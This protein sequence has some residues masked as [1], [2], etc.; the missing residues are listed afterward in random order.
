MRFFPQKL[1]LVFFLWTG[2]LGGLS[3]SWG[4]HYY[5]IQ[6]AFR[7]FPQG[8]SVEAATTYNQKLWSQETHEKPWL[9]GLWRATA[10]VASHGLVGMRLDVFPI[11]IVQ[12]SVQKTITQ[13]YYE[14][15]TLDCLSVECGGLVER[16]Q[17]RMAMALGAGQFFVLPAVGFIRLKRPGTERDFASEEDNLVAQRGGD[18]LTFV[19]WATGWNAGGHRFLWLHK[20]SR[21]EKSCDLS[22][23]DSLIWSYSSTKEWTYFV[24]A[25]LFASTHARSTGS[26]MLGLQWNQGENLSLF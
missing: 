9:Y 19:Q 13:R 6:G 8:L 25:G 1:A 21:M 15:L 17:V 22:R 11:S 26:L 2:L 3:R 14:T 12:L 4:A 18:Q 10:S 16:E 24:G 5:Q 7:T 23:L 20:E